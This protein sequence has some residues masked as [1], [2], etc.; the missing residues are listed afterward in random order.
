MPKE[1][2]LRALGFNDV[3]PTDRHDNVLSLKF[4]NV[5]LSN[6]RKVLYTSVI[7]N[8]FFFHSLYFHCDDYAGRAV[9][10]ISNILNMPLA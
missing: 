8:G 3:L 9:S 4:P 7:C 1:L 5:H 6:K 10:H 2:C